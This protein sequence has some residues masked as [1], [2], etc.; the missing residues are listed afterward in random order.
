MKKVYNFQIAYKLLSFCLI[1]CQ[2]QPGVADKSVA[3]KKAC[4]MVVRTVYNFD[5]RNMSKI[6]GVYNI[7]CD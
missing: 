3:Y 7:F 4:I 1:F 6:A 5:I 2:F